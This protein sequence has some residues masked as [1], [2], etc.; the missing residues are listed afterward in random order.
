MF[1]AA[2]LVVDVVCM[3]PNVNAIEGCHPVAQRG[4]SIGTAYDVQLAALLLGEPH[5]SAAEERGGCIFHS[6]LERVKVAKIKMD[7]LFE[8][9]S[10]LVVFACGCEL[11]KVEHVV[12]HLPCVVEQWPRWRL[13]DDFAQ[14]H[15]FKFSVCHIFVEV[16][17]IGLQMLA[18]MQFYC[19][20][21]YGGRKCACGVNERRH[22]EACA[23]AFYWIAHIVEC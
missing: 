14:R 23:G 8:V 20:L 22:A 10:G 5:P 21:A 17:Y 15:A 19:C 2:V 4:F 16:V 1:G 11:L 12:Q 18:V 7:E 13:G 6:F 9:S 3:F